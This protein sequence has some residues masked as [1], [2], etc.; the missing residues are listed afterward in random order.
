MASRA[1]T[2]TDTVKN[3][4]LKN[5]LKNT[6][7]IEGYLRRLRY[8]EV[9]VDQITYDC[10]VVGQKKLGEMENGVMQRNNTS[11]YR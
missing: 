8:G 7:K 2:V 6:K 3:T 1:T 11:F 4:R 9:S 5:Y 10:L